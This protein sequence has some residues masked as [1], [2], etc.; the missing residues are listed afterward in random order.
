M[1]SYNWRSKGWHRCKEIGYGLKFD[2]CL[3]III[4]TIPIQPPL[5]LQP[6]P[7]STSFRGPRML[8][9]QDFTAS[10]LPLAFKKLGSSL[11]LNGWLWLHLLY[12]FTASTSVSTHLLYTSLCLGYIANIK[13]QLYNRIV[14][15][16]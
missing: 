8:L 7:N 6:P 5:L 9:S 10:N 13:P 14:F 1:T 15:A 2:S 11:T 16:A 12:R 3:I 4:I